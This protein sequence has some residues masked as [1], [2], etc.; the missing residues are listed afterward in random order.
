MTLM[1]FRCTQSMMNFPSTG[2]KI[3]DT[4]SG[5]VQIRTSARKLMAT[6]TPMGEDKDESELSVDELKER[7]IMH[8]LLK[9]KN[10]TPPMRKTA[11][12]QITDKAQDLQAPYSTK[13]FTFDVAKFSRSGKTFVDSYGIEPL[14][15]DE[16]YFARCVKLYEIRYINWHT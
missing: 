15:I 6:P 10:R 16:D 12:R 9:I 11:L 1:G 7:N 5:Y 2:Y 8:L 13:S 14:L 3:L 4:P